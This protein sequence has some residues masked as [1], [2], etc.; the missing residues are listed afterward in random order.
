MNAL[1][2]R[3][4]EAYCY[5]FPLKTPVITSFGRMLDRPAVFVRVE[6][7]DR[8][9]GWGEVWCNFPSVGAEHRARIITEILAPWLIGKRLARPEEFFAHASERCA[10]LALQSGEKGPFAQAI[11]G[12]DIA[13]WD[14]FARRDGQPLWRILGGSEPT[15]RV[16]ASG[17]DPTDARETVT[18]ALQSGHRSFKLK[19]GFDPAK[20]DANLSGIR[21]DIGD[22]FLAADA[23]QAW[24]VEEALARIPAVAAFGLGWLEEPV[25]ADLPWPEWKRLL[26]SA[27]PPLAGGEN[28][29][30]EDA[31]RAAVE[32][33][34]LS[35]IQPDLAKWGGFTMC[36]PVAHG[37]LAAGRTFCPHY[38]GG[39]IGLLA[40]AHL[41]AGVGGDGMLE[42][43]INPNPLREQCCGPI[44]DVADG[45]VSLSEAPGLG[46]EPDL[47][48]FEGWRTL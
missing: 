10:V 38:L 36:A 24:S 32:A 17:V 45:R 16:Y 37:A 6:D 23:N 5:R 29:A 34:I 12:V 42:V 7:V 27:P 19:V 13:I 44:G 43:D 39:G 2:L 20:D 18:R 1:E 25:R 14:L 46:F 30:D 31:F 9:V 22:L 40:S 33:G 3:A 48:A 4:V 47:A 26:G 21:G 11:A 8:V 35:V 41:L 15:I 28:I